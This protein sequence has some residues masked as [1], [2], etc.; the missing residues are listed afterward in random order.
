MEGPGNGSMNRFRVNLLCLVGAVVGVISLFLAWSA[1]SDLE[2]NHVGDLGS[3]DF[4]MTFLGYR[5]LP[6]NLALAVTVF[7][8]GTVVAFFTPIAGIIQLLAMIMFTLTVYTTKLEE[9][10]MTLGVGA[11]IAI[12]SA[13][14]VLLSLAYPTGLGYEEKKDALGRIVT[15]SPAPSHA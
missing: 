2:G 9:R 12:V 14:L 6:A 5:L 7:T 10:K 3:Q 13:V 4:N 8:I 1:L 15:I 11:V